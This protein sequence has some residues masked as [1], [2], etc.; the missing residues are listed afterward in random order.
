MFSPEEYQLLDFGEG[1]RL[2]RFGELILDRPCP[3]ASTLRRSDRDLWRRAD[4]VFCETPRRNSDAARVALGTRGVWRAQT[5]LGARFF[6]DASENENAN[7]AERGECRP[8]K[9]RYSEKFVLELKGTPF[10]H[11]GAFPEQAENW[12]RIAELCRAAEREQNE[13]TRLLNL[14]GYTGGSALASA[15]AGAETTHLDAARNVVDRAKRNATLS[16]SE[17]TCGAIRWIVDDASKYV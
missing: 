8:W 15:S 2:E 14:F 4:A 17:S 11:V 5:P 10:G 13:P 7:G 3:S 1:R 16:F 9:I 12:D 6:I